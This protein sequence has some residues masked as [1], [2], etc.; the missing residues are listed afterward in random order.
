MIARGNKV[1][2]FPASVAMEARVI[3]QMPEIKFEASDLRACEGIS[4]FINYIMVA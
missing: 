2:P 1:C 4:F 3:A